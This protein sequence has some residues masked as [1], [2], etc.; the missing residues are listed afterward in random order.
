M[1]LFP[2]VLAAQPPTWMS[3]PG[4]D[5]VTMRMSRPEGQSGPVTGKPFSATEVRHT[6]QM[7][8]DGSR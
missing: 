3:T 5:C 1:V 4:A 2:V 7:L 8:A 6:V